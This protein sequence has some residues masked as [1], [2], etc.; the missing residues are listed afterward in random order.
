MWGVDVSR[1]RRTWLLAFAIAGLLAGC[2]GTGAETSAA[3]RLQ[4]RSAWEQGVRAVNEGKYAVALTALRQAVA[5]DPTV[6]VYWDTLGMAHLQLGQP[7]NALESF[8]RA[9]EID[10]RYGD[11]HFHRGT[12]L[13][14]ARR[15]ED[16][17]ASYRKALTLP[18]LTV[19]NQAHQNLGL[20]LYNLKQYRDAEDE[21]RFAINLDQKMQGAYYNLGLVF[22]AED[23]TEDAKQAFRRAVELGPDSSFGQAARERLRSMGEGG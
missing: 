20:A 2:A 3:D 11:A 5:L 21:L 6:P 23:R 22:A 9:V 15:W 10:P 7:G 4:A 17:V 14:E 1:Q 12:A 19:P 8:D 13:A 18:T 16:A